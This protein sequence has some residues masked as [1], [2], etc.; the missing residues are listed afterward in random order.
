VRVTLLHNPEAGEEDHQRDELVS[1]LAAE[2]HDVRYRSTKEDSWQDVLEE[3]ADLVVAAGGDGTVVKVFKRLAGSDTP[4]TILPAGSA[5]NIA[6]SLGFVDVE[7][8]DLV[9]AWPEAPTSRYDIGEATAGGERELFVECMG[10]GLFGALLDRADE[11]DAEPQGDDKVALSLRLLSQLVDEAEPLAF[12]ITLDGVDRSGE[13]LAVE[14]M[15]AR[16]LGPNVPLAPEADSSDGKL[17]VVLVAPGERAA[18]A[19]YVAARLDG[20]EPEPPALTV[21]RGRRLRLEASGE[22]KLHVDDD[23]WRGGRAV[24]VTVGATVTVLGP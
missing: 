16:E 13:Y 2:G 15:N 18:L 3:P 4:V 14:A 8:A 10:A 11:L 6:R 22:P 12:A 5:N 21:R 20:G 9:R 24:E 23:L 7:L 19:G 17:D 1:L